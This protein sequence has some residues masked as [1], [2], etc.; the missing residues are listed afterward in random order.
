MPS[1]TEP[2]PQAS[3]A[4]AITRRHALVVDIFLKC[5]LV[6]LPILVVISWLL[7]DTPA[8]KATLLAMLAVTVVM[9]LLHRRGHS[10]LVTYVMVASIIVLSVLGIIAYGSVRSA[11]AFAFVAAVAAAGLF[12]PRKGL[13]A[14]VA[15]SVLALG[16]LTWAEI[17]GLMHR[18][19]MEVTVKV[20]IVHTLILVVVALGI[21]H[22]QQTVLSALEDAR[23]ALHERE[24]VERELR[25]SQDQ[26]ARI[27]D[28][29]PTVITVQR[30]SDWTY[31]KINKAFERVYG[32]PREDILGRNDVNFWAS[33][34]TRDA[35][36]RK[37]SAEGGR[38][39]HFA[40]R[41]R[42]K[43]G[44]TMDVLLSAEYAGEGEDRM[45]VSI[46]TDVTR[47][48][49]ARA[50]LVSSQERFAKAFMLSPMGKTITR[51]SDRR[52]IEVNAANE[53]VLGYTRDDV[54]GKTSVEVGVWI[55]EQD[56]EDYVRALQLKGRL[57][58][59]ETRM[60]SKTGEVVPVRLWV[61]R[62]DIDG[63]P[64][65]LTDLVNISAEKRRESLLL[66]VAQGVSGETG[67]A[68]FHSLVLQLGRAIDANVVVVGEITV[69]GTMHPLAATMDGALTD[70]GDYPL[71]GTPTG[72]VLAQHGLYVDEDGLGLKYPES[73]AVRRYHC[74]AYMGV[75]L[76]DADGTAIGVLCALW[77]QPIQRSTDQEA[78]LSIFASRTNAELIRMRRDRDIQHLNET[79]EQ[80]VRERTAE[81]Q[82]LNAEM[83]SFSYSVSHDLKSPLTAINGFTQLLTRQLGPRL[84]DHEQRLFQRILAAT[85]RMEQLTSDMLTLARVS[86]G[87]LKLQRVDLSAMVRTIEEQLRQSAPEREVEFTVP[88]DITAHCDPHL[89]RIVLDNLIGNAWKYSRRQPQARIEF[90]T[91]SATADG[92]KTLIVRDNGVGFDMAYADKLF[93]P[94][95][96]LHG[97]SEFEGTGIGLATVH[98]ILERHGGAIRCESQEGVGSTFFFSFDATVPR[99]A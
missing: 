91:L 96:R 92:R 29:S 89:A 24:R 42:R 53:Q 50:L 34:E 9:Y 28:H 45:V 90:G 52:I 39:D 46:I 37:F 55:T 2:P 32:Y 51:L 11:G 58:A 5:L 57:V 85:A 80:R 64:C 25:A 12:L 98:R 60:R 47:E 48:V 62:I 84:T 68:F 14:A 4:D 67:S 63:E 65:V 3:T 94:F 56:R 30:A 77:R 35:L 70:Y 41:I 72:A 71:P 99:A 75:A 21:Y 79:L 36:R 16:A 86:R 88:P 23:S 19:N 78:L 27:F 18:D 97:A 31:L 38:L 20:W 17:A 87:E 6:A 1:S 73:A 76:R 81:L 54:L 26:M 95:H 82:A 15:I 61:E 93:K 33:P 44:D 83:E 74:Q 66:D 69:P 22:N 10:V 13:I 7:H 43:D 40:G 8:E 59:Y 49:Q